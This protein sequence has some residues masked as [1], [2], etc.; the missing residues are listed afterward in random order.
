M[1]VLDSNAAYAQPS[2]E[3]ALVTQRLGDGL[4]VR[5]VGDE[6]CQACLIVLAL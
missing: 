1:L 4:S 5:L 6:V 2:R 3:V